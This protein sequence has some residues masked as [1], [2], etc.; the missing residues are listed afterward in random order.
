MNFRKVNTFIWEK[1]EKKKNIV[2]VGNRTRVT[3]LAVKRRNHYSNSLPQGT[4]P[5][6]ELYLEELMLAKLNKI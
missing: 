5:S 1:K 3:H 6:M 4:G 2:H